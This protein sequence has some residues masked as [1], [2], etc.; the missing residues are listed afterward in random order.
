MV[1]NPPYIAWGDPHL[2][3]DTRRFEPLLA[4]L[5]PERG[6]AVIRSVVRGAGKHLRPGGLLL[7]EHGWEQGPEVAALLKEC[8]FEQVACRRDLSGHE[9]V[10]LGRMPDYSG[11]NGNE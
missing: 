3:P 8:G 11:E 6:L 4:L 5:A 9:R 1:C 2:A 10:T 7:L